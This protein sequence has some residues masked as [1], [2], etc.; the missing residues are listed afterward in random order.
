MRTLSIVDER[1][2]GT[3]APSQRVDPAAGFAERAGAVLAAYRELLQDAP[4][5]PD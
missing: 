3:A 5:P 4:T 1:I 2:A